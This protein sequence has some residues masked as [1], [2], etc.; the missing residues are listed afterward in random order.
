MAA[1][2]GGNQ[3]ATLMETLPGIANVLRS[4]VAD[5]LLNLI[6]AGAGL[7]E[8]S[9]G[10]VDELLKYASRRGLVAAEEGERVLQE[11]RAALEARAAKA[12]ERER[13][14]DARAQARAA[15][16]AAPKPA[17]KPAAKAAAKPV[18][19][20]KTVKKAK[21][22]KKAPPARGGKRR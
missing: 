4:P 8:F 1:E 14:R 17:P 5:A 15:S 9:V 7:R 3:I 11:V 18:K 19:A 6:R 13:T 10:E 2:L 21:P 12:A 16:A 22:A 20:I